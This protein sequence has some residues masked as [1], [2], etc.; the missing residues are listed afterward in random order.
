MT[1]TVS[2]S[3]E[4]TCII[5]CLGSKDPE[6]SR[7]YLVTISYIVR[8]LCKL[9]QITYLVIWVSS[10]NLIQLFL[11]SNSLAG[12]TQ[13]PTGFHLKVFQ[14]GVKLNINNIMR[15]FVEEVPTGKFEQFQRGAIL[16]DKPTPD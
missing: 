5:W 1:S 9:E 3:V 14:A 15:K 7:L 12:C 6:Q 10:A 8:Q 13:T 11:R 16:P 2:P 4:L